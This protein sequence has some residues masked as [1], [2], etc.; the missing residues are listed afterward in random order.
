MV[1]TIK[2]IKML[3]NYNFHLFCSSKDSKS[4]HYSF[5]VLIQIVFCTKPVLVFYFFSRH[6]TLK[7]SLN[8]DHLNMRKVKL[9]AYVD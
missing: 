2:R 8:Y 3:L 6:L 1:S 7:R 9:C 4:K 5:I